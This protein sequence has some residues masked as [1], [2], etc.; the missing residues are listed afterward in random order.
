MGRCRP[1]HLAGVVMT[2]NP[3]NE[4]ANERDDDRTAIVVG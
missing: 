1:G 4:D 2:G 3:D